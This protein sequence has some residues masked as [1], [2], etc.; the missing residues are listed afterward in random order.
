M[1][2]ILTIIVPAYNMEKYLDRCLSSL[3][4]GEV[5][6]PQFEVL[7]INDGA[8]DRTSEIAHS[9]EQKYPQTFR[10]IDKENGNYG[11][12]IN[13]GLKEASGTFIKVLDADDQYNTSDL[14]AFIVFLY[15]VSPE[16]D[17]I[18]NGVRYID[19]EGNII[20]EKYYSG[21]PS[22]IEANDLSADSIKSLSIHALT[23]KRSIFDNHYYRQTE[24]ISYTDLEWSFY[25]LQWL[26]CV[27][28]FPSIIYIYTAQRDGQTVA[29]T[30]HCKNM[31]MELSIV[32]TIINHLS[33]TQDTC[34][35]SLIETRLVHYCRLYI[36]II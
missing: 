1:D 36:F 21:E 11:S 9:Y 16:T 32:S 3:I 8:K 17:C 20:G 5:F 19:D 25:P 18:L 15:A 28:I 2:K 35:L 33:R 10:V 27:S 29:P 31:W 22:V 26:R 30:T 7:V 6:M 24:G 4:V 13:R 34:N 23:Y 14:E 12:C